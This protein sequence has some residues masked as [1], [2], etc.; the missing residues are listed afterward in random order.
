MAIAF[1]TYG[2]TSSNCVKI[3]VL[4]PPDDFYL[5]KNEEIP[6]TDGKANLTWTPSQGAQ[7][8]SVYRHTS[9]IH[10]IDNNGTLVISGLTNQSF[11]IEGL[12]NGDY[13][14]VIIAINPAGQTTSNCS[15]IIVRRKTDVFNLYSDADT[16]DDDGV[17]NLIWSKSLYCDNYSVYFSTSFIEN[18][19]HKMHSIYNFTP[20]F[21]WPTFRYEIIG[22]G[23]G[24]YY[25]RVVAFNEYGNYT[26][27]CISVIVQFTESS[28]GSSS[29][30]NQSESELSPF[31]IQI[32]IFFALF[33][34]LLG[35]F[36][37]FHKKRGGFNLKI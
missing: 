8:Y 21:E 28:S 36:I 25:Y 1:N 37:F 17:F 27:E 7:N 26:S 22:K 20:E 31:I 12:T 34:S 14:Y 10:E 3:T 9:Y 19:D 11:L 30:I 2:N 16:P 24:V 5:A 18:I 15:E 33:G 6:D 35:V 13:Y 29:G 4:Y 23:N 32:I